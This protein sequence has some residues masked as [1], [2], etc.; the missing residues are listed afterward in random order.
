[1][2]ATW[3]N[4]RLLAAGAALVLISIPIIG[5]GSVPRIAGTITDR[6]QRP[7]VGATV[8]LMSDDRVLQTESSAG[9]QFHFEGV[10]R[11][12]YLLEYRA[13]GFAGEAVS[14]DLTGADTPPLTII[15]QHGP[16]VP[17]LEEC[18]PH[19]TIAWSSFDTKNPQLAGV[20]RSYEGKALPGAELVATRVDNP[21]V[22]FNTLANNR[23]KFGF[24]KLPPGRYDLQI[25]RKS[26]VPTEVKQLLVPRENSVAVDIPM[27]RDD[28]KL[29][30][31]Q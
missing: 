5:Q 21:S 15:L 29:I 8:S 31:C 23:G 6:F 17:E 12:A 24:D 3:F 4:S 14:V 22:N 2:R 11:G 28:E 26:Y 30:V 18:G 27:K 20:I 10:P 9:G 1:M 13:R 16:T 25:F 7:V 19:P